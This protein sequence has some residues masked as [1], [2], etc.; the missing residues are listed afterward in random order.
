MYSN[1]LEALGFLGNSVSMRQKPDQTSSRGRVRTLLRTLMGKKEQRNGTNWTR[2][3]LAW[4][5]DPVD[6]AIDAEGQNDRAAQYASLALERRVGTQDLRE[7]AEFANSLANEADRVAMPNISIHGEN[8][9]ITVFHPLGAGKTSLRPYRKIEAQQGIEKAIDA[10]VNGLPADP[11]TRFLALWRLLPG[12][13]ADTLDADFVRL[14]ADN[15]IPDHTLVQHA[16]TVAGIAIAS[17]DERPFAY[18]S[19]SIGPVQTF[20]EAA[21]SVRDLWSGSA[22][23]SWLTF[24]GML[25]ILEQLGPTAFVFPALRGSPLTDLW[26]R[27][28]EGIEG[29]PQ[30]SLDARRA[31]SL[32]NRFLA[33]VPYG[34]DGSEASRIANACE[35]SIRR[36]WQDIANAVHKDI[37][38]VLRKLHNEWDN[39]WAEQVGSF[40]DISTSILPHQSL[41]DE[42]ALDLL[43]RDAGARDVQNGAAAIRRSVDAIPGAENSSLIPRGASR[44]QAHVE[45]SARMMEARRTMRHIPAANTIQNSPPKC[46]LLGSYEQLGPSD[47]R[48][49][50]RFWKSVQGSKL[51]FRE[52][53]RFCAVATVKRYAAQSILCEKFHLQ[54]SDLRFPDTASIAAAEWLNNSKLGHIAD[55]HKWNGRWLHPCDRLEAT[56]DE[57][58]PS[59]IMESINHARKEHGNPPTYFA[60]LM[61]D[62][63]NMGEWLS[64]Q[65]LP[66]LEDALHADVVSSLRQS[67]PEMLDLKRPLGPAYTGAISEALNNIACQVAPATVGKYNG[68]IIYAG[69]DDL[70]ALLPIRQAM[71]CAYALQEAF[72]G[73]NGPAPRSNESKWAQLYDTGKKCYA[74]GRRRIR[75]LQARPPLRA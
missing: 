33:L 24:R 30:P 75:T 74:V 31:P 68:T 21:R 61:M 54:A 6:K 3:I 37:D 26:L 5:H 29:V 73:V 57:T 46:S 10:I 49:S 9:P 25:P 41:S 48:K 53:E 13:L 12:K 32:P 7:Q 66:T 47:L 27:H 36:G 65:R 71:T 1:I 45:L 2:A 14:P 39:R 60:V 8:K 52:R 43:D 63:D 56:G 50:V 17:R 58:P 42:E 70:L 67:T 38:D 28:S 18:L 34:L 69:G 22:I 72:R 59:D 15:R 23:L 55:H 51:R 4:M 35:A 62:A 19:L 40:F 16:D 11:R 44:W 64:G 20:I